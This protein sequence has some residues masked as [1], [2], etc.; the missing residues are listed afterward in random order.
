M[1]ESIMETLRKIIAINE[2]LCDGCGQCANACVE[3][4]IEIVNGKAKLV[5][6]NYCDGLGACIGDCPKGAINLVER[7]AV[8]FDPNAVLNHHLEQDRKAKQTE[9]LG[10]QFPCHVGADACPGS[11]PRIIEREQSLQPQLNS[12]DEKYPPADP[13]SMLGNWPVQ[14]RLVPVHSPCFEGAN[15]LVAGDCTAYANR[16]FHENFMTDK[17]V[18]IG[19]PKLDDASLYREK[20]A[21]IFRS[22]P[23]DSVEVVVMEVPCCRGLVHIV[24]DAIKEAGKHF[25][26][27]VNTVTVTGEISEP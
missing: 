10:E 26:V 18:L 16:N 27:K 20:L 11:A 4:A 6:E 5:S 8:P 24:E 17:T 22:Q 7:P 21:D 1:E 25:T 23:I 19:C 2:E 15:I 12:H 9:Q 3:G 14:I 13:P